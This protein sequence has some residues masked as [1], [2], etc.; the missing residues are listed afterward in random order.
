M[1]APARAVTPS[2]A[3]VG[4]WAVDPATSTARFR[5]R[6]KLVATAR[7]TIAVAGGTIRIGAAGDVVSAR[8]ELTTA[9]IDTGNRHRDRDLRTERFLSADRHPTIVVQAAPAPAGSD[10]WTVPAQLHARGS[11]VPVDLTVTL[12]AVDEGSAAVR[13][14][15]RLDRSGLGIKVPGFV[16]ARFVDLEVDV[17]AHR[18]EHTP[19]D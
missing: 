17:R 14:T 10:G 7:G 1:T 11:S 18:L 15:G 9:S 3:M 4:W 16:I 13:I 6:D 5:V 2:A 19:A 12:T 8:V